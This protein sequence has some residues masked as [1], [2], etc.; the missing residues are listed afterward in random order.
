M[1]SLLSKTAPNYQ[2][3]EG[4]VNSLYVPQPFLNY[5]GLTKMLNSDY[6]YV[7]KEPS[8]QMDN[9]QNESGAQGGF[10]NTLF[11]GSNTN[12]KIK[13]NIVINENIFITI[14]LFRKSIMLHTWRRLYNKI[15]NNIVIF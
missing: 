3:K 10:G 2:T 13:R 6:K 8:Y 12:N 7:P 11:Q 1:T 5:A 14:N 9:Q 15:K 4:D